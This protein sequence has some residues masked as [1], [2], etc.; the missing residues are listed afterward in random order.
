MQRDR[1]T[2]GMDYSTVTKSGYIIDHIL[3]GAL[4]GFDFSMY[5]WVWGNIGYRQHSMPRL[6]FCIALTSVAGILI[7][8]KNY[9]KNRG[10][11]LDIFL[12]M[13]VYLFTTIRITYTGVIKGLLIVMGL[14]TIIG[15][16]LI[17]VERNEDGFSVG[18]FLKKKINRILLMVRRNAGMAV[19]GLMIAVPVCNNVAEKKNDAK[20]TEVIQVYEAYGNE[21]KLGA[22]LDTIKL[23]CDNDTFQKLDYKEKC[24]VVEAVIHCEARYLGLCKV[25]I[26]FDDLGESVLGSYSHTDKRII[27]NSRM[28]ED[29]AMPDISADDVL[30]TCVHE[31]RHA[32]Q[33]LMVELY[34]EVSPEQ[35][36]LL[37]FREE[38]V[39]SWVNNMAD[40]SSYIGDFEDY[41]DYLSQ[42]LEKDARGYAANEVPE[43]YREVA[44]L[45][46]EQ[47]KEQ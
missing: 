34:R 12:G 29:G 31:C 33:H 37:A 6:A 8:F 35:R 16:L 14:L 22:N 32:Y 21:Y 3:W 15:L 28:L 20:A 5:T 4:L 30:E 18:V 43:Y 47:E 39:A 13:G 2:T 42:A 19:I 23:I 7:S 17:L 9:R 41:M 46:A 26:V 1:R 44:K 38:N 45:L 10:T 27:I 24:R 36:N 25:D 11:L 40:Y